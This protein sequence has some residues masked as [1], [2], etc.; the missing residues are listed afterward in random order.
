[1]Q[2]QQHTDRHHHPSTRSSNFLVRVIQR[3]VLV[4]LTSIFA[5]L[6]LLFVLLIVTFRAF[7]ATDVTASTHN[8]NKHRRLVPNAWSG[9]R[10]QIAIRSFQQ[11]R[12]GNV[13]V[14]ETVCH[15]TH[16]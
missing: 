4:G 11:S 3:D 2:I 14:A 5:T 15:K 16:N 13:S 10:A 9:P 6:G 7:E 8:N 12:P 1:M